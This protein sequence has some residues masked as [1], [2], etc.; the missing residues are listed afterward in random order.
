[1]DFIDDDIQIDDEEQI[2]SFPNIKAANR[3]KRDWKYAKRRKAIAELNTNLARPLHFYSKNHSFNAFPE[4]PNN[5]KNPTNNY[6]KIIPHDVRQ[7]DNLNDFD[8]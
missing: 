7:I 3:R 1:M 5:R 8:E 4:K 6:N 2:S